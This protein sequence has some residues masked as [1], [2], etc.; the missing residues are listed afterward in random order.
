MCPESK[1]PTIDNGHEVQEKGS[2]SIKKETDSKYKSKDKN[3][4]GKDHQIK[5]KDKFKSTKSWKRKCSSISSLTSDDSRLEDKSSSS[6][7]SE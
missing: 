3:F 5:R 4:S 6:D 7:F 1:R 2:N